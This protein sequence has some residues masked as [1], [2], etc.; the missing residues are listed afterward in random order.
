MKTCTSALL[1]LVLT[2]CHV[3]SSAEAYRW[4]LKSPARVDAAPHRRL[5]FS[6]ETTTSGGT[7]EDGVPFIWVVDW[8]G[9]QGAEHQGRSYHEESLRVKGGPGTAWL[10]I[11][12]FD[13]GDRL[14]EVARA[15]VE[16]PPAQSGSESR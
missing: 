14:I 16:I 12:A 9:V 1:L 3:A 5:S 11:L 6:V 4:A 10:R 8:V 7:S 2:S 13:H 15:P